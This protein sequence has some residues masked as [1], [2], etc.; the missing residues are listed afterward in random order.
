MKK[1]LFFLLMI[2]FVS[3]LFAEQRYAL[4]IGNSNYTNFGTLRNPVN[5]AN[6]ME[7]ALKSLGFDVDKVLDG[8]LSRMETAAVRLRNRLTEAGNDSVGFFFFAGHGVEVGGVN[9][10][11]PADA[12]IP[13]RNFLRERAFSVQVMLDM[14]NDS[15]NALNIVVLDACRN[16]PAVWSR[17][18]NRGLS[19]IAN[20]PANH[21][22]MYATGAGTVA[23]DGT[24]RNGLFTGHLL[25]NMRQPGIEVSDVFRR[26]MRDVADAS[27][28]QQRPALYTDFARAVYFGSQPA[29]VAAIPPPAQVT[30]APALQPTPVITT[31]VAPPQRPATDNMVRIP[32]GS[33]QRGRYRI[34]ISSFSMGKYPVTQ[35][36]WREVMR[37]IPSLLQGDNLPVEQITWFDAVEYCN[38]LSQR[39]G[40]TPAYTM[41]GRTPATGYPITAAT[42]TWNRSANG[43]CLPTEAEWEYAAR[44]GNGSPGNFTHSGSNNVNEV[45]W[46][47]ANSGGSTQVVGT[48]KPNALGLYDMSGNVWE[49]CWDW[50]GNYPRAAQ[51]DPIGASS[52]T[53]RVVRGG[54][55]HDS[56]GYARSADRYSIQPNNRFQFVG[57]RLAH[58]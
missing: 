3:V 20:P 30:P 40:L 36:E 23:A 5:D 14:L 33:F 55:W 4:V 53:N 41:T 44:G 22:I 49:W 10:L 50:R 51:T 16:F 13:D 35:K 11:I 21:I 57:F 18:V 12:N 8:S 45:A 31:P 52:G 56:A 26:T 7:T 24:G 27:N 37:T 34:T 19:V 28:N 25:H 47:S 54:S 46:Y 6:D 1:T 9:Y 42:V 15:R 17:T 58:P 29:P 43:Y 32:G 39:E 2:T 48:K 38:R